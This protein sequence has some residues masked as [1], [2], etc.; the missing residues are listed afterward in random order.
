MPVFDGVIFGE[1][2]M[3]KVFV[4]RR[5]PE[6]G[7]TMLREEVYVEINPRDEALTKDEIVEGVRGKDGL[8]CLLADRID[9]EVMDASKKL[10]VIAN[11]AVGYDNIDVAAATQRG[12]V[13]SNTP[14]VLTDATADFAWALLMACARRIAEADEYTRKGE[15]K[16]WLPMLMLGGDVH[17]KTLGIIG[18]GRIGT[19]VARRAKGFSMKLLYTGPRRKEELE[20]ELKIEYVP[21]EELLRRSDFVSLHVPLSP[22]THHL[23]GEEELRMMKPSAYLINTSRGPVMDEKALV[24]ALR[25][26]AIAGAALDVYEREPVLTE[27]LAQLKNVVLSPHIASATTET[28]TKMAMISARNIL[29]ALKGTPI[30]VVNEEV[31]QKF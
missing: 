27:G 10:M 13:V 8:L 15:F 22:S 31:L 6:P 24:E 23:I 29:S 17:D 4:T 9:T 3:K 16:S 26:K 21:K 14:G 25:N 19:A 2:T 11:Y 30:N 7:L 1:K 18:L 20:R 28:R 5:I 12:I